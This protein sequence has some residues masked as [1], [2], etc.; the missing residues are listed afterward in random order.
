MNRIISIPL[1]VISIAMAFTS[2]YAQKKCGA[3]M[4]NP[5]YSFCYNGKVYDKCYGMQ[6]NPSTHIC[7]GKTATRATCKGVNYDPLKQRCGSD[8]VQTKCG[9]DW[10]YPS[11]QFCLN[12]TLVYDKCGGK[13]YAPKTHH[14]SGTVI[15]KNYIGTDTFIDGR[16]G[17]TYKTVGI[18]SQIWMAEN[19][20]YNA[21][22]SVCYGNSDSNCDTY[23]RL[24][25]WKT[26]LKVCPSGWHLPSDAEWQIL[27]KFV[28]GADKLKAN[29]GW[30]NYKNFLN[31][32]TSGNGTDEYGFSA[33]PGGYGDSGG[34]FGYVGCYGNWWS[35]REF[36][37]YEAWSRGMRCDG[38]SVGRGSNDKAL[39]FSVRCLK[40]DTEFLAMKKEEAEAK[41]KAE[42]E[43]DAYIKANGDTFT[44]ARDKKTYKTIKIANQNWMA[45]NLNYNA[46][47]SK[48]Y[49]N[50]PE[51]CEKYG[52]LY[53]WATAMKIDTSCNTQNIA[54][55]K[56]TISSPHHQGICPEGWHLPSDEEWDVLVKYVDPNWTSNSS[57]GNVSGAKLKAKTG[58]NESGNG[59]DEYGFS[60]LPGGYSDSGGS[61][62]NVGI[63]GNWWSSNGDG[64]EAYFRY[65]YYNNSLVRRG[66]SDGTNLNS[67][68]CLQD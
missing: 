21:E 46:K 60:A 10:Y 36:G 45:E 49:E 34:S 47:G 14:C 52:R 15:K 4:F 8:G 12:N 25:N 30:N 33:L 1:T 37:N 63:F 42:A 5:N 20:N 11:T 53:D 44:D 67:V 41:A 2:S 9:N 24:Y 17:K 27:V 32:E 62:K 22:G 57:D 31:N 16:D 35:S 29:S 13:I 6:Y 23:G 51:N 59:T 56:A 65:M 54:D 38:G 66:L 61:F 64:Y 19:L 3:E 7:T 18:V 39:L 26:A 40:D 43:T 50:K 68:R 28:D 48:C 55:C 58:W